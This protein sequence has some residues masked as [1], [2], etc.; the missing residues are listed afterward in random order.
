[1]ERAMKLD[2]PLVVD[3]SV[4]LNWG[5]MV[6]MTVEGTVSSREPDMRDLA[7]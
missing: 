4:G 5:E 3:A 2:A 6:A 7:A 1:M